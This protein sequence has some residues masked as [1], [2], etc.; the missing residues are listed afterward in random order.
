MSRRP[1]SIC[2]GSTLKFHNAILAK[3]WPCPIPTF[4][5]FWT[6]SK[7][8]WTGL[9][10][11]PGRHLWPLFISSRT[12]QFR[13]SHLSGDIAALLRWRNACLSKRQ[14]SVLDV[15]LPKCFVNKL[16]ESSYHHTH[17][18]ILRI[19]ECGS[20]IVEDFRHSRNRSQ[21]Q[22]LSLIRTITMAPN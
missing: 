14:W 16:K 21:T 17:T 19:K 10:Q 22:C 13:N 20:E 5:K 18:I 2:A 4:W 15:P 7:A 9:W 11:L 12:W 8:P 6:I 1:I 3:Q